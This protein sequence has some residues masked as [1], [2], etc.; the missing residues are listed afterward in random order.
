MKFNICTVSRMDGIKPQKYLGANANRKGPAPRSLI[1]LCFVRLQNQQTTEVFV[2]LRPHN[3]MNPRTSFILLD[4]AHSTSKEAGSQHFLQDCMCALH[5]IKSAV[6]FYQSV[7]CLSEN[8]YDPWLPSKCHAKTYQT[9]RMCRL[10]SV[11]AS[12]IYQ[13][14]GN[15]VPVLNAICL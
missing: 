2:R 9:A 11:F 7:G 12:R 5:R 1:G 15:D 14:I 13:F 3:Y 4:V 8:A 6:Q 10:I